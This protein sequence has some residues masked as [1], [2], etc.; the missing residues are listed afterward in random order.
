LRLIN[1]AVGQPSPDML[2]PALLGAAAADCFG[3]IDPETLNY[4]DY[5]GEPGFREA[6]AAFLTRHYGAEV[7]LE[8]LFL[9]AGASQGID[10]ACRTWC[11]S[12]DPI[13]VEEP[14]YFLALDI[15]ASHGLRAVP[16]AMDEQGLRPDALEAAARAHGAKLLYTIP[17]HHNPTARSMPDERRD[18]V[19]A[20]ARRHGVT[21]LAD[22]VY[23]LLHFEGGAP[24]PAPFGLRVEGGGVVSVGSF[25]KI[26]APA[27]RVGWIQSDPD[28]IARLSRDGMILSGGAINHVGSLIVRSALRTGAQERHL[29]S[30]RSTLA[31][32]AAVMQAALEEAMPAGVR[33]QQ[34][35]GGYF[36]WLSLP[37][38][39]DAAAL[40]PRARA[41]GVGFHPG[42]RFSSGDSQ[43]DR[44]R[45]SFAR[46]GET[47]IREAVARLGDV[48][49]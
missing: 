5:A 43:H 7:P 3:S 23:Q 20:V 16:V 27:M 26:L 9:T 28:T 12:G 22:E 17:L 49:C 33:W 18:A 21:V 32:R 13:L 40:L 10:I 6:L 31:H 19:L 37:C 48:L 44:L 24:A 41:A 39:T 25:S 1:L 11:R 42:N 46:Y 29:A 15:F 34:P 8:Q 36:F 38:G 14:S 47:E 45:L 4:G 2:D 30:V 35:T